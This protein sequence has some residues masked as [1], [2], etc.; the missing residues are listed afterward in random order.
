M[1]HNYISV[2]YTCPMHPEILRDKP[3]MCPECG[4]NLI[5]IK[6]K[7]DHLEHNKHAGHRTSS[8]L[9]KFWITLILTIPIFFYSEMADELFSF[10]G[11]EFV[12]WQYILL[13]LGSIIFFYCGWIFISSAHRELRARLPGMMTLIA[14]AITTAYT[15]SFVS[16]LAGTGH[17]LMFELSSLIAIMLL[18]H[19]IE[20]RAVQGA[21]GALK[22]LAKLLPD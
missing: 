1:D 9:M 6:K 17:D 22:E 5:P 4:M 7:V 18:G 12:G 2:Q 20:M 19:W 16:I 3:E 10:H 14:I 21:K 15:Y 8:F 13:I 11:P